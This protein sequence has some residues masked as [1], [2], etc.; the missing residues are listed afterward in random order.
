ML[1][2]IKAVFPL[3][4]KCGYAA[5]NKQIFNPIYKGFP[6]QGKILDFSVQNNTGVI[7]GLD[8]NRYEF[9]GSEWKEQQV[10]KRG[11][12]VDF[13]VDVQGSAIAVYS[14]L[15][16]AT[17]SKETYNKVINQFKEKSEDDYTAYDWCFKCLRN[18]V[19]FQGRARRKEYWFFMLV[20]VVVY[21]NTAWLDS[22][23][24]TVVL[25]N[26]LFLLAVALPVLA[27]SIRRLHDIDKSGW[28]YLI[29]LVPIAGA[30]LLLYWF[31]K[32]GDAQDNLYGQ[33]TI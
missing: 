19:N 27:V 3:R 30:L 25:F 21:I 4:S 20:N 13:D 32:A 28:W 17:S 8:N 11:M 22:L 31:S 2:R 14:A 6:M 9:L 12:Q 26:G 33:P 23:L 5:K 24:G 7:S 10:P 1:I 29:V 18:Y 15:P 16:Q